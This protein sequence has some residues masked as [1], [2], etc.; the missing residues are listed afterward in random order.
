MEK[1]KATT[2]EEAVA[3]IEQ[4]VKMLDMGDTPLDKSLALFEE[5]A[6][7]IKDCGKLL[8][9]AEQI[10]VQLQKSTDEASREIIYD[11]ED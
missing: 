11:R 1:E 7:L 4:I 9:D 6:R 5:G 3:R 2:F 8:D 10:V